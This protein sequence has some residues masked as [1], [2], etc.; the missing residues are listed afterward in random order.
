[1]AYNK[2]QHYQDNIIAIRIAFEIDKKGMPDKGT[3]LYDTYMEA[4]AKYSGFGEL[5]CV[6]NDSLD[7]AD[8]AEYERDLIPLQKELFDLIR[9]NS[10]SEEQFGNYIASVR[11]SVLTAFYTPPEVV[12]AISEVIAESGIEVESMLE[13]SAGNGVF[14]R[15][16]NRQ[17]LGIKDS[18]AIEKDILTGK[19]LKHLE[20]RDNQTV[21]VQGF[22]QLSSHYDNHFD[23]V[24]SNIPFGNYR[25]FDQKFMDTEPRKEAMKAIHNYFFVKGLDVCKE[26]GLLAFIT[27]QGVA[28]S[29]SNKNIRK[30]LMQNADLVSAI[31]LPNNLF[32]DNA[33][34]E[35]G[36]DLIV[37]KKTGFKFEK[38]FSQEEK[39]FVD[40][41]TIGRNIPINGYFHSGKPS[42]TIHT[43]FSFDTNQYGKSAVVTQWKD[44]F[45]KLK[46]R[47]KSKLKA[48]FT[49]NLNLGVQQDLKEALRTDKIQAEQETIEDVEKVMSAL[50]SGEL[51]PQQMAG[52]IEE[53]EPKQVVQPKAT[54]ATSGQLNLFDMFG[55]LFSEPQNKISKITKQ[56]TQSKQ[57]VKSTAEPLKKSYSFDY[58]LPHHRHDSLAMMD[59]EGHGRI[60]GVIQN[61]ER[62]K[63]TGTA[64]FYPTNDK[65]I[66]K[67]RPLLEHYIELRDTYEKLYQHE[68]DTEQENH[69]LR[70]K[71]NIVYDDFVKKFGTVEKNKS[72]IKIADST[73]L[74]VVSLE[75]KENDKIVKTDIFFEPTAF[76]N[77][78]IQ[79]VNSAEDALLRSLNE[80]GYPDTFFM[81]RA[82]PD[83]DIAITIDNLVQSN[84]LFYDAPNGEYVTKDKLLSGNMYY[85]G[86]EFLKYYDKMESGVFK[87]Y[88]HK[89][90]EHIRQARPEPIAFDNIGLQIGE[91]WLPT[92]L[93]ERFARELFDTENVRIE[94]HQSIDEFVVEVD[95]RIARDYIIRTESGR[96]DLYAKDLFKHALDSTRP[97]I[98]KTEYI[99]N[100]PVSV[101]DLEKTQLANMKVEQIKSKFEDFILR[102]PEQEKEQLQAEY[103]V[104]FN[105]NARPDFD[106]THQT[107]PGL[108]LDNFS[109][110]DDLY[111]SQ[112]N[113]IWM[114]KQ[115][116]GG[117]IDHEV[118]G[119]KTLTMCIAAQEMKRTGMANLPLIIAMKANV[120]AIAEDYRKVYPDAK[121]CFPTE[122]DYKS[123]NR[124]KFFNQIKNNNWDVVIMSHDNF[125]EIPQD[126][127]IELE[128][129]RERLQKLLDGAIVTQK[130]KTGNSTFTKRQRAGLEKRIENLQAKIKLRQYAMNQNRDNELT[131]NFNTLGFDHIFVD[132]SH[133]FK[134]LAFETKHT[135]V[136][137]LGKSEGSQRADALLTAIRTIQKKTANSSRGA[138]WH[139]CKKACVFER[140]VW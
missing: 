131:F 113:A 68:A 22:E 26:G 32:I 29:P 20:N 92:S 53:Q 48:D 40:T 64:K 38:D 58:L 129:V 78:P 101:T 132:E 47:L 51:T 44:D 13:P 69:A 5:K 3:M 10:D 124:Q 61:I 63:Y 55:D 97:E 105:G 57:E 17:G 123:E 104:R 109:G 54:P 23:L 118:G 80:L 100:K 39:L 1:M 11:N 4:L 98:T 84:I 93:Y 115:N 73:Y 125:K 12:S 41:K 14:V 37:L 86:D 43:D 31:R 110:I 75:K 117:I 77:K 111:Q 112:K 30:Y 121:I 76:S 60:F 103:N 36:T 16:F 7:P 25:V 65:N 72:I 116:G 91:R 71:F 87:D 136:A 94:Y 90:L 102:L 52:I 70:K 46:K 138:R 120:A 82:F 128:I 85:K 135:R 106:G 83:Q 114:L 24:V 81:A 9:E 34:T 19:I 107:F 95:G 28:D 140:T 134:N 62:D 8:W 88:A 27:S 89:S 137:G 35:A 66:L 99:D 130:E 2:K 6:L 50:L 33:G 79:T 126:P 133:T 119:G 45:S 74:S 59:I 122:K 21:L 18:V 139:C 15:S 49:Q 42:N 127:N 108:R 56:R 96:S 67:N